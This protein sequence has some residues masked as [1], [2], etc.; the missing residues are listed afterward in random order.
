MAAQLTSKQLDI[1]VARV[2]TYRTRAGFESPRALSIE[3][4]LN[5]GFVSELRDHGGGPTLASLLQLCRALRVYSIDDLLGF[6]ATAIFLQLGDPDTTVA[7]DPT[8]GDTRQLLMNW[9]SFA[10]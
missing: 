8:W 7:Q 1:L 2:D 4:D 5:T 9:F 10:L 3:A 6:S